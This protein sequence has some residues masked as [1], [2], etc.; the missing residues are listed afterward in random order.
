LAN[1]QDK[2]ESEQRYNM[3][4]EHREEEQFVVERATAEEGAFPTF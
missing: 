4:D 1:Q 3:L 2:R